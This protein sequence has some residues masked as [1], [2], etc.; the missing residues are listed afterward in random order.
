MVPNLFQ[1]GPL[2][3]TRNPWR[4]KLTTEEEGGVQIEIFQSSKN[5][6]S[7]YVENSRPGPGGCKSEIGGCM[8]IQKGSA[9]HFQPLHGTLLVRGPRFGNPCNI[10]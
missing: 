3:A 6:K 5:I 9:G 4:A 7:C 8:Q 2:L 1:Q 10:E